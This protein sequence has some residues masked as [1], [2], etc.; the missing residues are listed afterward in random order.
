MGCIGREDKTEPDIVTESPHAFLLGNETFYCIDLPVGWVAKLSDSRHLALYWPDKLEG[1][2]CGLSVHKEKYDW[3]RKAQPMQEYDA[4]FL[5]V[6]GMEG[7]RQFY[8]QE[9]GNSDYGKDERQ[10]QVEKIFSDNMNECI[11]VFMEK[12]KYERNRDEL[13]R[14]VHV[15]YFQKD[16]V[17]IPCDEPIKERELVCVH[18]NNEAF[19]L[20]IMVPKGISFYAGAYDWFGDYGNPEDFQFAFYLD[21]AKEEYV[22]IFSNSQGYLCED[23]RL[24]WQQVQYDVSRITDTGQLVRS[25]QFEQDGAEYHWF[26]LEEIAVCVNVKDEALKKIAKKMVESIRAE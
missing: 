15:S 26:S 1:S 22:Q 20:Q 11:D 23:E 4:L 6:N 8:D 5:F 16:T 9:G 18:V 13:E 14:V 19:A 2:V 12:G 21:D 3:K 24:V 7:L 25:F 17:G 10:Y